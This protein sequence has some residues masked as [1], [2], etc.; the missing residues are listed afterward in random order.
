MSEENDSV[1]KKNN[2][3]SATKRTKIASPKK[4]TPLKKFSRENVLP[5]TKN[6]DKSDPNVDKFDL[7]VKKIEELDKTLNEKIVKMQENNK[8]RDENIHQENM[9]D[10]SNENSSEQKKDKNRVYPDV[11]L[12]EANHRYA[13]AANA[14]PFEFKLLM[15]IKKEIMNEFIHYKDILSDTAFFNFVWIRTVMR[16]LPYSRGDDA[17]CLMLTQVMGALSDAIYFGAKSRDFNRGKD[18]FE[19]ICRGKGAMSE[20]EYYDTFRKTEEKEEKESR[21]KLRKSGKKIKKCKKCRQTFTGRHFCS[22]RQI[23]SDNQNSNSSRRRSQSV[24]N[25]TGSLPSNSNN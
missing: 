20:Q 24:N 19:K 9:K 3:K 7:L 12:K 8:K 23:I 11:Y 25:Q 15:E 5:K 21:K 14:N 2:K 13:F 22:L 10:D 18:F 16:C 17:F 4:M 1:D 6:V